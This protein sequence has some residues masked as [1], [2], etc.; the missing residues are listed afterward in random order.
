MD[1]S[2]ITD[3]EKLE[4]MAYRTVVARDQLTESLQIISNRL[5][6]LAE[7]AKKPKKGKK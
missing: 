1:V 2:K 7:E 6:E 5:Q 4:A 3:T